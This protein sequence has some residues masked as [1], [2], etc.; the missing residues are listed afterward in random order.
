MGSDIDGV[1]WINQA[2][3]D[4][5]RIDPL[6]IRV[7]PVPSETEDCNGFVPDLDPTSTGFL[8]TSV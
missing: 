8:L 6:P 7:R 1:G 3:L 4:S 5:N 2:L